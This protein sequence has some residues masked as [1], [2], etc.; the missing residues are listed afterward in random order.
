MIKVEIMAII[1]SVNGRAAL[2][3]VPTQRI[4]TNIFVIHT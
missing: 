4:Y 3:A 2:T 1:S